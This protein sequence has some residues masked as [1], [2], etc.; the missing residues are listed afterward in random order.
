[1]P[2]VDAYVVRPHDDGTVSIIEGPRVAA[3]GKRARSKN[4]LWP[5]AETVRVGTPLA[6]LLTPG[7]TGAARKRRS[8][9]TKAPAA[10]E[11]GGEAAKMPAP[12]AGPMLA[13]PSPVGLPRCAPA[14]GVARS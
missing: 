3:A 4:F 2:G 11:P 8:K 6:S 7:E 5:S 12:A 14:G 10:V 9:R 1:M 13:P